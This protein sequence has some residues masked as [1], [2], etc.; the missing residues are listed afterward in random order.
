[1]EQLFER[2]PWLL[3]VTLAILTILFLKVVILP[4]GPDQALDAKDLQ[5]MFYPLHQYILQTLQSGELPL[6][7]PHQFIGH[8]IIGNPHAALFYPA[9]W[10]MWLIGVVR[11]M[12][13][14]MV[15]HA[16]LGAWGMASLARRFRASYVGSLLA[17]VIYAMSQ[18]S[19]AH[20][21]AGHYNLL[22]VFGW[23]PWMM[24]A[25]HYALA[26]GTWRS[27]LPGM[28]ATGIALLAGHPP[29]MIYGGIVLITL[30]F[31]HIA[32]ADA[33]N[34]L[35]AGWYA[36]RLLL[37]TLVGGLI[38]GAS[39]V[40]PAAELTMLSARNGS[41]LSFANSFALP[42]AQ[43]IGLAVPGIFGNPKVPPYYYW[44]MDFFEEFSAYAGLLPLLAIALVFRW[45]QRTV[46]HWYF[47]GL[48]ALGVVMSFGLDGALMPI[49]W[50]WVP[51]STS[52][53]TPGRSLYL[54][55]LGLAGLTALLVTMLQKAT[56]EERH[57]ALRPA[58]RWWLPIA[59]AL[60]FVGS[61]YFSGWY[62]SASHVEPMPLRAL[63][64]ANAL[65]EAGFILAV[66]W[67]VLW[68]WSDKTRQNT[69]STAW[70]LLLTCTL[71]I[72]DAW[73]VGI[74]IIT[75]SPI[76]EDAVWAGARH[77]VPTGADARVVAPSGYENLASVTGHL[78]VSGYDPLPVD[79]YIKLQ[80]MAD[81]TDP[82]APINTLLGVKYVFQTKP[83]DKSNFEL[84]GINGGFFYRRKDAF[85]RAWIAQTLTVEP[86][87]NAVRQRIASGKENL[88][89]NVFI[90]RANAC[91]TSGGMVTITDYRA[92]SLEIKTSG[93]GGLLI[94][95][96]Q[97]YPGWQARIDGQPTEIV[98][99]DTVFRAVCVP[100]GDHVVH[101]EYRP[102]SLLV[103]VLLSAVGWLSA[104]SHR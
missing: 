2:R 17:G 13:L 41:D 5:S 56:P 104:A 88:L 101:Y 10:F 1:M 74:P 52:F 12:N 16:W 39:L 64:V 47:V 29:L 63:L 54:V 6:W 99:A 93:A 84:I 94:L 51:G 97:Y 49:L 61:A 23:I 19:A 75:V 77:D 60:A 68:L 42:P 69:K 78:N 7:N 46:E 3:P 87:D 71:V 79:S 36:T 102:L 67:F 86:D 21:Y 66:T 11:G 27:T 92:N 103:G 38:L 76:R 44:G 20:F 37:L 98:R 32:Q 58:V 100:P 83:Y 59:S 85:P 80:K 90:D 33:E 26:R 30:W 15:F 81:A 14:S 89:T 55:M 65:A 50:N 35:H 31:Y 57:E 73:H 82:T 24:V 8:P 91:P 53:R 40:I 72:L 9:T 4:P 28:A 95:S 22:V 70:A 34:M 62:A 48:I 25:Y 96:D 18:W 45:K 43:L